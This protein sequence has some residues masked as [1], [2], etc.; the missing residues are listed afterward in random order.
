MK[1]GILHRLDRIFMIRQCSKVISLKQFTKPIPKRKA[2]LGYTDEKVS[3]TRSKL[4]QCA[5]VKRVP[6]KER[7]R[8]PLRL[9]HISIRS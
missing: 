2:G 5:S 3:F 7:K 8:T 1:K 4:A 9:K 6:R